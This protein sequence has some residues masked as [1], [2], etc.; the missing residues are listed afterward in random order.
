LEYLDARGGAD[1]VLPGSVV[2]D[3]ISQGNRV[4][5]PP[6]IWIPYSIVPHLVPTYGVRQP[7]Q[8]PTR[9]ARGFALAYCFDGPMETLSLLAESECRRILLIISVNVMMRNVFYCDTLKLDSPFLN[10]VFS[11]KSTWLC[12]TI[13]IRAGGDFADAQAL[14]GS[15]RVHFNQPEC[16]V[17]KVKAYR[18]GIK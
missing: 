16:S 13:A 5:F 2:F 10:G 18:Y 8:P 3:D 9:A 14:V 1:K 6:V 17:W 7:V 12:E 15:R 11:L 4:S